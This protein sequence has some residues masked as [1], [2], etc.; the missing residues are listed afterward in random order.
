MSG[1]RMTTA[2]DALFEIIDELAARGERCPIALELNRRLRLRAGRTIDTS[3][4]LQQ[5]AIAGKL[6]VKVHGRNWRTI[7]I[8]VGRHAGMSTQPPPVP[9][10]VYLIADHKG[11]R[12][13][14]E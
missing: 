8:C 2:A 14:S 7:E 5:L 9:L 11:L 6:I 10:A 3:R 13:V 4:L 12:R 1:G